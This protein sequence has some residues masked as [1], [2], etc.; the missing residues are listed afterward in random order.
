MITI[1][2]NVAAIRRFKPFQA[3]QKE[4]AQSAKTKTTNIKRATS[5]SLVQFK[6]RV[7]SITHLFHHDKTC[8]IS[9]I[10]HSK[11]HH[12]SHFN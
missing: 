8:R 3:Q 9:V 7:R 10:M 11:F 2:V 5:A 1:N 12:L 6:E 4:V